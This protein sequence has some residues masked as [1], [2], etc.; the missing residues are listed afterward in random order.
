[1]LKRL[2]EL[3]YALWRSIAR[4]YAGDPL[5]HAYLLYDLIYEL[6]RT[7][8]WF[9]VR[10]GEVAGYALVWRGPERAGVHVW[11]KLEDPAGLVPSS[12]SIITV[13]SAGLLEPLLAAL[14]GSAKGRMVPRHG[15]RRENLQ[16]GWG[17]EGVE[18]RRAQRPTR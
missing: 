14:K 12:E 1:M 4:L 2:E 11:G 18:A 7:D 6:E 9:E 17:R 16:A 15:R 10:G 8:A 5:T 13:H 3:D